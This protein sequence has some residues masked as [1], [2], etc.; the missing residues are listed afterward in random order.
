[1]DHLSKTALEAYLERFDAAFSKIPNRPRAFFNDSYEVYGS[2]GTKN[3]FTE[4]E[5]RRGYDLKLHLK[6]LF[7][8]DDTESARRIQ[9]DYR[10]TF[11][12]LLMNEFTLPWKEWSNDQ[13]VKARNQAHGSPG[14][15]LDLYGAVDI[16]ECETFGSSY[17]PIPGLRRDSSDIRPVDPDPIM[18][19]FAT[20]AANVLGKDYVS[21][22]TFTWLAEHFRVS[23][24]QCKP[25]LEQ[26]FLAGVNH[27]F[28]HG[29]TYSPQDATWPGWL[30]YASVQFGP[31]NSFWPHVHGLNEYI[32][33]SQSVLQQGKAD[34]DMLIYWPIYDVWNNVGKLDQQISIHN[35]DEWLHPTPFYKDVKQLMNDGYLVDFV[36]DNILSSLDVNNGTLSANPDGS[37]Y[38]TLIIPSCE[39]MPVA[40]LEKVIDLAYEG[41]TVIF[42]NLP[43]DVPGFYDLEKDRDKFKEIYAS[44][45]DNSIKESNH[46]KRI[47]KGKIILDA[48]IEHALNTV[49][50]PREKLVDTG[51]KFVRRVTDDDR[52]YFLVNHTPAT[53][54]EQIP[55]NTKLSNA[56]LMDP[57]N[58]D[59]GRTSLSKKDDQVLAHVQLEPGQSIIIRCTD[60]DVSQIPE[61]HYIGKTEETKSLTGPWE[62]T[63]TSGGPELPDATT[64]DNLV[65]WTELPDEKAAYFS[66]QGVYE[67]A[68]T[69][70][71]ELADEYILDLGKV[72]ESARVWIND[73]DVGVLWSAPFEARIGNVF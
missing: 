46:E 51:L 20:S 30:F 57:D 16:P 60:K 33:R 5:K 63:F 9:S 1:M 37:I 4:F 24:S 27:V 28:Y 69:I 45:K 23:L 12:E 62:L 49:A 42:Q 25:E 44:L 67:Y 61:W 53:I 48:D 17:F 21:S 70:S 38:K 11:S 64:L 58:G 50:I 31:V 54:N 3:I 29:I 32:A 39:L 6:E 14:N 13:E 59:F 43:E 73:Q 41:A 40:T 34:S 26:V 15:I 68:L 36:S 10:L 35:I 52:Y 65:S 22:E 18:M 19:K 2:S 8:K 71:D 7:S 56:I 47:G 66:G 72:A 55:L